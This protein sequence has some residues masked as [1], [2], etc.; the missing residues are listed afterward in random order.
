[1]LAAM[2]ACLGTGGCLSR[3]GSTTTAGQSTEDGV[4]F[5]VVDSHAPT[6]DTAAVTFEGDRVVVTG[7]ADP[8]G[9]REP[10]LGS[11]GADGGT[12]RVVVGTVS[13]YG[14]DPTVEC[15]N[16]SFD[17]RCT[18]AVDTTP[19]TVD[20]VHDYAERPDR[21]FSFDRA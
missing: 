5:E 12:L 9:C 8:G 16:A 19:D 18:V 7:T 1:M 2:G 13:P 17:Y 3:G 10:T 20:V 4:T 15:G 14:P 11:V 6:D 21:T